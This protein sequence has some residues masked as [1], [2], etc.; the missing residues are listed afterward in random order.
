M[1][2]C[3]QDLLFINLKV[4]TNA[5]SFLFL[6]LWSQQV[7]IILSSVQSEWAYIM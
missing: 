5:N 6:S 2:H 1:I 4:P 3:L 7:L